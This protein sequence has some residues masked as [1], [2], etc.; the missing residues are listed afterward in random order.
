[1]RGLKQCMI[2]NMKHIPVELELKLELSTY[3]R[4]QI[5]DYFMGGGNRYFLNF[6]IDQNM[7]YSDIANPRQY[8]VFRYQY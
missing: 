6:S 4:M 1:M 7:T 5:E 3:H 8:L 2:H